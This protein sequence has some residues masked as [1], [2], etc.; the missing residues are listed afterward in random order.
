MEAIN[1]NCFNKVNII[2]VAKS[3]EEYSSC[4]KW[5]DWLLAASNLSLDTQFGAVLAHPGHD[6]SRAR[7]QSL[8]IENGKPLLWKRSMREELNHPIIY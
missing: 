4:F 3:I 2:I 7:W 6:E 8:K 5:A 1:K